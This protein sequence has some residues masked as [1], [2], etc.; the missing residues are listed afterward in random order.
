MNR[1]GFFRVA[2]A[3]VCAAAV[4]VPPV[5]SRTIRSD[6]PVVRLTLVQWARIYGPRHEREFRSALVAILSQTNPM[7][8]SLPFVEAP[9]KHRFTVLNPM[10]TLSWKA[11]PADG[12]S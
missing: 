6:A 4:P 12:R 2:I 9:G 3:A 1:R 11:C 5:V 10:P 8:E 7:M